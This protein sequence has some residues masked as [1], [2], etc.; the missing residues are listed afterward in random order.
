MTKN[1]SISFIQIFHNSCCRS[2]ARPD[3][4]S[5]LIQCFQRAATSEQSDA[6]S[7]A[8]DS[9]FVNFAQVMSKSIHIEEEDENGDDDGEIDQWVTLY[10]FLNC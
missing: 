9:L 10:I 5:Q 8:D 1:E 4:L 6:I 7:I 2:L 3:P